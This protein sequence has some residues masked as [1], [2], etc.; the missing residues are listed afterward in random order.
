MDLETLDLRPNADRHDGLHLPY[1]STKR[2]NVV[3]VG[4][5]LWTIFVIL[6][7]LWLVGLVSSATF[8]GWIHLLLIIAA[9]VL[10]IQLLSGRRVV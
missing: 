8:G 2:R 10:V 6:L 1:P 7:V 4:T 9:V 3:E 5:M